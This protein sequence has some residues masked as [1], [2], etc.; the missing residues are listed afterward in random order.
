[1]ADVE[2]HLA[3]ELDSSIF[4]CLS[5]EALTSFKQADSTVFVDVCSVSGGSEVYLASDLGSALVE[6]LWIASLPSS[7]LFTI[8]V[9]AL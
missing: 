6:E 1:M 9:V 7:V 4:F 8:E 2:T 5:L 3:V